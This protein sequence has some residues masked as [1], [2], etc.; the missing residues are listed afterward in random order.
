MVKSILSAFAMSVSSR[1]LK[2]TALIVSQKMFDNAAPPR[3]EE[4]AHHVQAVR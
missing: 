4:E 1:T 2:A 3:L